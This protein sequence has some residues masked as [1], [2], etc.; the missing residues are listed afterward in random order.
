MDFIDREVGALSFAMEPKEPPEQPPKEQGWQHHHEHDG[1]EVTVSI[2]KFTACIAGGTRPK[3][4]RDQK[5]HENKKLWHEQDKWAGPFFFHSS[6]FA[7]MRLKSKPAQTEW[8]RGRPRKTNRGQ[9]V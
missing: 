6:A 1:V 3:W 5:K 4:C 2:T 7:A 9:W 8:A